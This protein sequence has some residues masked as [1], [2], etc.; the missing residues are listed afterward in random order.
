MTP[1]K[2][3]QKFIRRKFRNGG[4]I[5]DPRRVIIKRYPAILLISPSTKY[6]ILN[7]IETKINIPNMT[8]NRE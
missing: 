4:T 3:F 8:T 6:C 2:Y 1:K 7:P 5:Y